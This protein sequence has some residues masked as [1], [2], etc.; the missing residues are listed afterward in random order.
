[1]LV[2]AENVFMIVIEKI[3]DGIILGR[4]GTALGP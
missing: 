4:Y 2:F 1:M 3:Y